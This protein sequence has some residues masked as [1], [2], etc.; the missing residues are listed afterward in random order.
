MQRPAGPCLLGTGG[1]GSNHMFLID[2]LRHS[3]MLNLLKVKDLI[4]CL[5]RP[6]YTGFP[7]KDVR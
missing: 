4:Y 6:T 1:K 7:I 5:I 2:F 3:Q